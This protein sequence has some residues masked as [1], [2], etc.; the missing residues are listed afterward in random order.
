MK[1]SSHLQLKSAAALK[2]TRRD[3]RDF[4]L[5]VKDRTQAFFQAGRQDPLFVTARIADA[6]MQARVEKS[7]SK[8]LLS[9][10]RF[11]RVSFANAPAADGVAVVLSLR[12]IPASCKSCGERY[13]RL[14]T[15]F[16]YVQS[17]SDVTDKVERVLLTRGAITSQVFVCKSCKNPDQQE[18]KAPVQGPRSANPTLNSPEYDADFASLAESIEEL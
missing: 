13:R 12:A 11:R 6:K 15:G 18:E 8:A 3:L 7:I 10:K 9:S 17:G 16:R 4:A 2:F 5:Q 14:L 1:K